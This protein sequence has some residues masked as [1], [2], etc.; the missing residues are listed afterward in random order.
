MNVAIFLTKAARTFAARPAV[1]LGAEP[2]LTYG[3]LSSRVAQ[4]AWTLTHRF[5]LQPGDRVALAMSNSPEYVEIL[6]A[7]WHAGLTAVPMNAKLHRREFAYILDHSGT[8][9][10][11]A[12][13]DLVET[14]APLAQEVASLEA[15]M[16]TGDAGYQAYCTGEGM[17]MRD[18]APDAIAWLFYTS[19][20]TG[21]P[22]G[23]MLT[24]RN[25]LVMTLSYFADIDTIT[26]DDCTIHAAPLSHGSG[27]YGLPHVAKAANQVIPVSRGFDIEELVE[28]IATYRG[29]TCF[30]APTMVTRLVNHPTVASM[31]PTHLK[32]LIYGGGPMY[33]EDLRRALDLF[34]PRLV[35]IYGQGEAP[36]TITALSKS[37]H[38]D[39]NHPRYVERLGSAGIARSDVEVRVV[40]PSDG[41]L[42]P[43]E[44]GEVVVRGDVVMRG[45]WNDPQASAETLRGGWL[46]TGD[47]GGF[48]EDG[49]L[50]LKD[51]SKDMIISGGSNIY[52][53]EIEE[54]LL[55]H[56]GV[57]EVSVVG[58]PH[59][60]WGEEVVACVVPRPQATV[61]AADLDH[62]CLE[63]IARY[64]RPR[65]YVFVGSLPKNNYGKVLKTALR[66]QCAAADA[67]PG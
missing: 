41:D 9:L 20:T 61:T 19:G 2:Y 42:P 3:A 66:Q 48:N 21:R 18:V 46:H 67:P 63:T 7:V 50:T 4:L 54:V 59:R 8:R 36:M 30:F 14:V 52:P 47:L 51:R 37:V 43:G 25:L 35:Q 53:R 40:D 1:S 12:T 29:V 13:P 17:P 39:T 6:Y 28:L 34:G 26:P 24:H 62:L 10:C 49:F 27:L 33:V 15:V 57:L 65:A 32:T 44:I 22:K 31:D 5:G 38:A 23:A 60:E 56:P 64:K 58:R 45:Y 16:A 55:R 11:F